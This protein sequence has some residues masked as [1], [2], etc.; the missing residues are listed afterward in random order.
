MSEAAA[1][2]NSGEALGRRPAEKM[3]WLLWDCETTFGMKA[4]WGR[5]WTLSLKNTMYGGSDARAL[6]SETLLDEVIT[7]RKATFQESSS[8]EH[9]ASGSKGGP[10]NIE[11]TRFK[12]H[13]GIS[14]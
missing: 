13:M 9:D 7:T 8:R 11:R 12:T 14:S 1:L 6:I 3:A 4:G 5:S 2:L 10:M